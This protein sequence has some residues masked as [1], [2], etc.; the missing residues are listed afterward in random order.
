MLGRLYSLE[1]M[2]LDDGN[3]DDVNVDVDVDDDGMNRFHY[4]ILMSLYDI[5][6][7]PIG[8]VLILILLS[9]SFLC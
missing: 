5:L 7:N 4:L 1:M 2:P 9:F 6:T 3:D 8:F